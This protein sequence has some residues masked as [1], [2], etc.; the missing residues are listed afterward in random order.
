MAFGMKMFDDP[1]EWAR[2][3]KDAPDQTG[4][5]QDLMDAE[6]EDQLP[7]WLIELKARHQAPR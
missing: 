1:D 6:P 7:K 3:M 5:L 4:T 2:L